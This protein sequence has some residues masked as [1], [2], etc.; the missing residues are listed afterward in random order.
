MESLKLNNTKQNKDGFRAKTISILI[1]WM[2]IFMLNSIAQEELAQLSNYQQ[3]EKQTITKTQNIQNPGFSP[4]MNN[5]RVMSL[6]NKAMSREYI[7][8]GLHGAGG[9]LLSIGIANSDYIIDK[10]LD[11]HVKISPLVYI[12]GGIMLSGLISHL[13]SIHYL[14]K[15]DKVV[16]KMEQHNL[17][18]SINTNGVGVTYSF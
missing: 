7:S 8:Y 16:T 15:L 3:F 4:L 5:P 6:R 2:F 13:R 11:Y 9:I 1:S 14:K 17:N 12:G 18:L 10:N